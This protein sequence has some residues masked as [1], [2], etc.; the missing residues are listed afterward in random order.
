[1]DPTVSPAAG[2][3]IGT[4]DA[5]PLEFWVAV[6]AGQL[7]PARRRRRPRARCCPDGEPVRIYG[8]GRPGAGPPRGRPLRQRRVPHRRRACCRPRSARRRW[9]WPPASSPRSSCRRCRASAVRRADGRRARR[10]AVLRRDGAAPARRPVPRRRAALPRT[11]SSSTAPGAPTSTSAASPASPPRP[12]TPPSCSTACSHSGV[13]GAEAANTKALIFNVK[14]EDLL[15]LDHANTR[16]RPTT[17]RA[18]YAPARAAG[19]AVRVGGVLRP[20]AR[21]TTPAPAP[22]SPPRRA[23]VTLVLLDARGVLRRGAAAVPVRRRRGRPPAVH[24]G[25]PQRDRP[26]ARDA[27]PV[28][29]RRRRASTASRCARSRELVDAHRAQGRPD[30]GDPTT[31]AGRAIGAGTVN[32]FVRRL[33]GAVRHVEHL[34]RADV[35]HARAPPRRLRRR[36]GHG[37]RP[38]QPQRPGQAVRRRRRAAPGV[39]AQGAL[40][41]RPGRC[42]SSCSTSS[43][44]TRPREGS[45]PIKEILLDVAERGRSLGIILIGAQQTASEVERRIVAN[46]ADPG[47]RPAR[48]RRG[49]PGRVRLPARRCSASGPRSSSRAR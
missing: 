27:E 23:G 49:G 42:S 17:S 47:R 48:R 35:A 3:V 20:A 41:A 2:R 32:A 13:L 34:I 9:S 38:A 16:P 4:E 36:P 44:S 24:D 40:R 28:R 37:G 7:P 8:V 14:G 15:F 39:R 6:G 46:S 45:S 11:S 26:A 12:P 1:M 31:W 22:T 25:R 5:T 19:R 10:G 30:D 21:G 29:R 33:H 18:R 43:T